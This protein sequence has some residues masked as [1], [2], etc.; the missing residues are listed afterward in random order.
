MVFKLII[1]VLICILAALEAHT[2]Q[3]KKRFVFYFWQGVMSAAIPW[4]TLQTQFFENSI[5]LEEI[6]KLLTSPE[7]VKKKWLFNF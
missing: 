2:I 3:V 1:P 5:Y 4:K 7:V 6:S